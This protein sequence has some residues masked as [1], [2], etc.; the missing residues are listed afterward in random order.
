[1]ER[2]AREFV[3]ENGV[4]LYHKNIGPTE[5]G[6]WVEAKDLREGDVFLGANGELTTVVAIER[7]EYPDGIMVYN[8]TV[9]G[10]HNY[11]V[12]AACD[13]FGQTSVLV[14]NA[15]YGNNSTVW[16]NFTLFVSAFGD[17]VGAA[18]RDSL[19]SI[20]TTMDYAGNAPIIGSPL[21]A[22]N[23]AV[24]AAR[25]NYYSATFSAVGVLPVVGQYGRH[26]PTVIKA[27]AGARIAKAPVEGHHL[28]PTQ[29]KDRFPAGLNIEDFKI[30]LDKA[31][32]RLK[33]G[34]IHTGPYRDSWN[35]QWDKFLSENPN[36]TVA[37]VLEQLRKMREAFGI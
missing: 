28:L 32:H 36:A 4:I 14:H 27:A 26:A 8:F 22:V 35:G 18:Y 21:N 11:F 12:I 2:A 15:G 31:V 24:Y 10:N 25:G 9:D 20:Q 6:F 16:G 33:P 13:E 7:V 29:F 37:E 5:N 30:P 3:D 1:L 23:A 34:G 17:S 19:D